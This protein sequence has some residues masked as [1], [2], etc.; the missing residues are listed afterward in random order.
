MALHYPFEYLQHK[1]WLKEESRLKV[2][3]WFL[4]TKSQELPKVTCVQ[5]LCHISFESS[6]RELQICFRCHLNQSFAQEVIGIQSGKSPNFKNYE[7]P[8]LGIL[9]KTPFG[10]S[11]YG[12]PQRILQGGSWWFPPSLGHGESCEFVYVCG[13]FMHQKMFQLCTNQLVV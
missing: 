3:I 10:Y 5:E 4:T 6:W 7:T 8:D 9:K 2:S 12:E 11:P 13:S 1:L